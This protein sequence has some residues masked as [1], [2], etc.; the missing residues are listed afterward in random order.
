MTVE[1]FVSSRFDVITA[2]EIKWISW[3]EDGLKT[4]YEWF[5]GAMFSDVISN[6]ITLGHS[7]EE[8]FKAMCVKSITVNYGLTEYIIRYTGISLF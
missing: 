1:E 7:D 3:E 6:G 4:M 8:I 5:A 2:D